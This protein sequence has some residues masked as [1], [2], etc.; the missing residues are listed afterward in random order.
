MQ[1]LDLPTEIRSVLR[2]FYT[3]EVT[4]V[5]RQ[6]AAHHLTHLCWLLGTSVLKRGCINSRSID[7]LNLP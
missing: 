1:T 7:N 6:G 4:T 2:E 3:C 5:N